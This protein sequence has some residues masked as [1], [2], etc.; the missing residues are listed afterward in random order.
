MAPKQPLQSIGQ[1]LFRIA[2]PFVAVVAL[3]VLLAMESISIVSA[4]RAYVGGESMWCKA[5]KE[6]AYSLYRYALSGSEPDFQ[7]YRK[8]IAVPAG[9]RRAR[10]ALEQAQPDIAAAREGFLAGNNDPDDIDGM[11]VLFRRFRNVSF[12]SRTIAVWSAADEHIAELDALAAELHAR[13]SIDGARPGEDD[14]TLARIYEVN[15]RL[16]E[17]EMEFSNTLGEASRRTE[18]ILVIALAFVAT[19]LVVVGI[20]IS[21]RILR[22]TDILERALFAERDRARVTLESIGDAVITTDE[23]GSIVYLNPVAEALTS[24]P[25]AWAQ[26]MP[27]DAV[28]RIVRETSPET[29]LNPLAGHANADPPETLGGNTLLVRPNGEQMAVDVSVEPIHDRASNVAGAVLVL[30]DVTRERAHAAQLIHQA[31]HD[32]LTG[33]V[34]RREFEQRLSHALASAADLDRRHAVLFM[35]LDNFKDVNDSGGH[36]AG[37]ALLR[38]VTGSLAAVLRDR[39][40]LGRVGGDEFAVLLENCTIDDAM[41]IG[42]KLRRAVAQFEF[43][44]ETQVFPIGVSIGVVEVAGRRST[45]AD[46]LRAADAS[47]YAAKHAGRNRVHLHEP[48]IGLASQSR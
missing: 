6:A 11:I 47:C 44:W 42:E 20:A 3:L 9:D 36:A 23:R 41:R 39:D 21:W 10:L 15:Q 16:T 25:A 37:D 45:V 26:G 33:L 13:I 8:A 30:K 1:R 29:A 19:L 40:T 35:D 14:P 28:L 46:V 48:Q 31:R 4:V 27:L 24:A 34:N 38:D 12:M 22:T 7:A 5:Q 43:K 32:A 18:S 2:W 17:L